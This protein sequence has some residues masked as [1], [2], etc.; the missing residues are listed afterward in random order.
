MIFRSLLFL[1]LTLIGTSVIF[2]AETKV[3]VVDDFSTETASHAWQAREPTSKVQY[4][5]GAARLE[6]PK[7]AGGQDESRWPGMVRNAVDLNLAQ[8]NGLLIDLTNPTDQ[9]QS[10]VAD[11]KG[12][13][14]SASVLCPMVAPGRRQTLK[15]GFDQTIDGSADWTGIRS[16]VLYQSRPAT[17]QTWLI[18]SVKLY[19]DDPAQTAAGRLQALLE[20]AKAS[21][22]QAKS[23]GIIE[24]AVQLQVRQTLE[25]WAKALG[26]PATL[27]GQGYV[28]R[29]ELVAL[30]SR[31][32]LMDLS[33]R[34]G[35]TQV[36]WST[37]LGT[38]FEPAEALLQYQQPVEKLQFY[39]ARG[40]YDD[41]IVRLTNL[42]AVTQDW[43]VRFESGEPDIAT[44]LSIRRNQVIVAADRSVVGD[45]LTPLDAAGTV[46]LG[47]G[48]TAE[49][50]IRLDAKH[51]D[52]TAGNHTA[53]MT[54]QDLRRGVG[55]QIKLPL[56]ITI[57]RFDLAAAKPMHLNVWFDTVPYLAGHEQ[58][59]LDNLADYGCDV[60][61]IHPWHLPFPKLTAAGEPAAPLELEN[62]DRL[63][64]MFRGCN[65]HA[66]ILISLGLDSD[67]PDF[68]QLKSH[69][70]VLSPAWEKGMH[71]WLGQFMGRMKQL[72]V[73]LTDYA[74]YVSDEPNHDELD[75]TRAAAK[76]ARAID[77]AVQIYVN[78]INVYF[79]DPKLNT[80]L[81][82]LT[83]IWQIGGD[84]LHVRPALLSTLKSDGKLDLWVYQCRTGTRARQL[85]ADACNYY[86]L[87]S[88][89]AIRNGMNGIGYWVY[90]WNTS[91]DLWDGTTGDGS[92]LVYPDAGNGILASVRWELVRTSLDDV[93]YHRLLQQAAGTQLSSELKSKIDALLGERFDRVLAHPR[94]PGQAVQWRLDA[95]TA[96]DAA[97]AAH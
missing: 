90:C 56:D 66:K 2:A 11:F 93:K 78:G 22:R 57:H 61:V 49:L 39:A 19:C 42:S 24:T 17:P 26:D 1:L 14:S 30:Q 54:L 47:P 62:F 5:P 96:L 20:A 48:D 75:L 79:D 58:A 59:S 10:L 83:N 64:R 44:A 71:Y 31:L 82:E 52:Q 9:T 28:C 46:T 55:S 12:E 43:R 32:R 51:H 37:D 86:R 77:P 63:V 7:Y 70:A 6:L 18:H 92:N 33:K 40:Q 29:D 97:T 21:Y 74:F 69:L 38:R 53:I 45:V 60:F 35:Q 16:I 94:D 88:W 68:Q 95:G 3:T 34:I 36:L 80:Q 67:V 73:P 27:T 76:I 72:D 23:D 50:W 87:L 84:Y 85:G 4:E 25:R 91:R 41:R 15:I 65:P 89:Q 81:L 13:G 8:Y